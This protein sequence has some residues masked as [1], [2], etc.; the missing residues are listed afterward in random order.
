MTD[1][2]NL[3]NI[4][5]E[6]AHQNEDLTEIKGIKLR[7]FEALYAIQQ[8]Y[9]RYKFWDILFTIIEFIQLMAFPLDKAFDGSWG[10]TWVKTIGNFFRYFQLIFLWEGTSFY[11]IT[12]IITCIYILILFSLFLYALFKSTS[13]K[14]KFVIKGIVLMLQIQIVLH[15]PI[16]RTLF[17]VFSCDNNTI[18][19]SS[20]IKCK[21][22]IHIALIVISLLFIIIFN[23]LV[24]LFHITLYE[25]GFHKNKIKS[26]YSSSTEVLLDVTKLILITFY[27]FISHQLVLAII[28]LV[29]SLFNLI[30]FTKKRPY[31]NKFTM[32]L[33]ISLYLLF[34]W[35]CCICI[36]SI[37]MKH[38]DFVS[39]I[40][41][42]LLGY[43]FILIIIYLKGG[44]YSVNRFLSFSSRNNKYDDLLKIEYFL[45]LE[46]SLS[47]KSH[48]NEF[49][50]L[51]NYIANHENKCTDNDCSLKRFMKIE[52]RVENFDY[53]KLLL[54]RYVEMLYKNL[55]SKEPNNIKL[56]I[57]YILFLIKKVNKKNKGKNELILLDKFET[58]LEYSFQIYK[59]QKYIQCNH[60][61][62]EET[63]ETEKYI[64]FS[65]STSY[66]LIINEIKSMIEKIVNDY[67]NFWNILLSSDWDKTEN[68]VRMN[69][70]GQDIKFTDGE[71]HKKIKSLENWNLLDQ[72]TI[73]LYL[74]YLKEIIN[75]NEKVNI[76]SKKIT[77]DYEN[78]YQYDEVNLY[79][80]NYEELSK[81]EDYRY[82][83]INCSPKNFNKI[84]NISLSVCKL[85]G[86][87]REELIG[88]SADILFPEIF[89][90]YRKIFFQKKAEE[91]KKNLVNNNKKINA[92]FWTGDC[93]GINKIKFLIPFKAKWTLITTEDE[94][95]YGIGNF[96]FENKT[97]LN[98]KELETIYIL[99]NN[100]LKIKN[101]SANAPEMLNLNANVE[102][103]NYNITD[104]I[105]ELTEDYNNE[106]DK[107]ESKISNISSRK[108][109][110]TR[111]RKR[112]SKSDFFKKYRL[113]ERN[114]TKI[115]HWKKK[116]ITELNNI[117]AKKNINNKKLINS[118]TINYQ[119]NTNTNRVGVGSFSYSTKRNNQIGDGNHIDPPKYKSEMNQ[120]NTSIEI[121]SNKHV[122]NHIHKKDKEKILT[123]RVEEAKFHEHKVGY[124][125][126]L[127]PY[128][129][130]SDIEQ[131]NKNFIPKDLIN[132][133]ENNKNKSD[134]S[135]ISL[136]EDK[137]AM[138]HTTTII[139][140][141]NISS[142]L[143]EIF[144][145][146]VNLEKEEQFTFD[147]NNMTFKQFKYITPDY[148]LYDILK[149]KAIKKL[150][151]INKKFEE[152]ESEEGEESSESEYTNDEDS[153]NLSKESEEKKEVL[154][155]KIENKNLIEEEKE[156]SVDKNDNTKNKKNSLSSSKLVNQNYN[157]ILND[158]NK[159][160][161]EENFYHVNASKISLFIFNYT[162]GYVE[163]QKGENHKM[164]QVTYLINTEKEKMKNPN[165]KFI[166]AAK[167]MKG[168][169]KGNVNKKE[170]NE[171]NIYNDTS[172][173]M[174]EIYRVLSSNEKES[175]IIKLIAISILVFLLVIGTGIMNIL[176]YLNIKSNIYT[177]YILIE[178]SDNLYQNLLFEITLVK[179]MLLVNN[180]YYVVPTNKSKDLYYN[181]LS[182]MVYSYYSQNAFILS[183]L[184]N[185]FNVLDK[186]DEELITKQEIEIFILDSENLHYLTYQYKAY[187]ILVYSAFR[188]LNSALYHIS[189]LKL[190]E[191]HQ[192]ND[193][194]FYFLKNGM[195]NL[196]ITAENQELTLTEKFVDNVKSGH[197]TIIIFCS[198][199]FAVYVLC[200]LI[201]IH[202]YKKVRIKKDK[203]IS[204]FNAFD[205]NL[206]VSSL[207]KCEKFSQK[208]QERKNN[209]EIKNKE[210]LF[211]SSMNYSEN[212]NDINT[213]LLDKKN[214]G[215]KVFKA[216]NNKSEKNKKIQNFNLC[217][218]IM[219]LLMFIWQLAIY[220]YYYQRMTLYRRLVMYG[221]YITIFASNFLFVF[222]SFREYVF[223]RK[224]LFYNYSVDNYLKYT[225]KNYYVIYT[226]SSKEKD[227]YRVYYPDSYFD[228]INNLY[229]TKICDFIDIY[230]R[231][232]PQNKQLGCDEF[233]YGSSAYGFIT[234][235]TTF[236]EEIRTLK[237]KVDYYYKIADEK[238]YF[239]NESLFNE[240]NGEYNILYQNYR[241]NIDEYIK[242][243][244][245]N[246]FK[247]E[248]H[249]KTYIT[250]LYINTQ[251]FLY[252]S[253][254]SLAQFEEMFDKYN[255]IYLILNIVFIAI[256]AL[257]F[258]L[259]WM[260]FIFN[261]HNILFNIK[262]MLSII[263]SEILMDVSNINNILLGIDE[264]MK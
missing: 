185:N 249:K 182:R 136:G 119:P 251:I 189:Q 124:I 190:E 260:P 157:K 40:V 111:A 188:E 42:L 9:G 25:F 62:K 108:K 199:A 196:I 68:F 148:S 17:S 56:R 130:K 3:I 109:Q 73:K 213:F 33:Y 159:K 90:N 24:I 234:I 96:I 89:N 115:I 192:Y 255:S 46:D 139:S 259:I 64:D 98:D 23:C 233:F 173:K 31:S 118:C 30:Q 116:D 134:T 72:D 97:L 239:Y 178:K 240:P 20:E 146:N 103:S 258:I 191:I 225:L 7:L 101:Y 94:K 133:Q 22:V 158:V 201:F 71:L 253:K 85:F 154:S 214:S 28:T 175:V 155:T 223:D 228:F 66:K 123:L 200:S 95:I 263:P 248:G 226:N 235:L 229:S 87:S 212:D 102:S 53:L 34:L 107:E 39:G 207:Q 63:K 144:S 166:P 18:E 77:L 99:T 35:S 132:I 252:L 57:S 8:Y 210:N 151:N 193:D 230:N 45:R 142:Q 161:S 14:N 143:N 55:I 140:Q 137:K 245:A 194:V 204:I 125:F 197:N 126:I 50:L 114:T 105:T 232:N 222:I 238:K 176:V 80:L 254:E 163:I 75:H 237:D 244:P 84:S 187:N 227:M 117:K 76:Y 83:I 120:D 5:L 60:N 162:T 51:F 195:S 88:R 247:T 184:T 54:L 38:S 208:L 217:Q 242:Y 131:S 26:G 257:G 92:D 67:T 262:N 156:N 152:E 16:L 13:L 79:E 78:K 19:I 211:D 169:K 121:N 264:S 150:T 81:N 110:N 183:N 141:I 186:K 180:P 241:D 11:I 261:Q 128:K 44:E 147:V 215:D 52:F 10:K 82:L 12:D 93:F 122:E 202:F 37:L 106:N 112:F 43:P 65:H 164:S 250:Y 47:E 48:S 243:N 198:A 70:L 58:N 219:F 149:E 181:S 203:Y 165:S 104:Y 167:F 138:K 86:Y 41:L 135:I 36:I 21:S 256:V 174:K 129:T 221:Y 113:P 27:Q 74:H 171:I 15:I 170:E 153:S 127:Q 206:I 218:I 177:F 172:L 4:D 231:E 32:S 29:L 160:K 1:F 216:K 100:N 179:E 224:F 6:V 145:K 69:K 236:V 205:C 209:K 220:I 246:I 2:E 168:K 49:Q 91:Y 59:I 61:D